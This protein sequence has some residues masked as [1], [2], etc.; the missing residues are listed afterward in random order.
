[1]PAKQQ[2]QKRRGNGE[3][4]IY[5]RPDGKWC[6]Q[7]LLGYSPKTGKA[8]RKTFYGKTRIEVARKVT[9][10]TG[11]VFSGIAP[12][13]TGTMSLSQFISDY[14]WNFKK[15]TIAD[16]TFSWYLDI[17]NVYIVPKLGRY[18]IK[19]IT[20]NLIQRFI[21]AL[22]KENLSHR[23]I[24]A[25]RD[26]LNQLFKHAVD[27]RMLAYNP[28]SPTKLPKQRRNGDLSGKEVKVVPQADREKIMAVAQHD[29]RMK[30]ALTVLMMTGMRTGEFLALRWKDIDFEN[31]TIY[32]QNAIT[33]ENTYDDNGEITKKTTIIG[34]T[35]TAC[36][37]RK[38]SVPH[39]VLEVIKQWRDGLPGYITKTCQIDVLAPDAIIF[40]TERGKLRTYNGFR[41]TYRRFMDENSLHAYPLHT[42]RHTFATMLLEENVNPK[43]VQELLGH[44]DVETTLNTYSHVLPESLNQV[45][46]L[47]ETLYKNTQPGI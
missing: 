27:T 12:L 39:N 11:Q 3:G 9:Q 47:L 21:N 42:Y 40:P 36:S 46:T 31:Q 26:L 16:S 34:D 41:T 13:D 33:K 45:A 35:K 2:R 10:L 5:Q 32:I 1:M 14:L 43:I 44:R 38:I 18:L 25:S 22:S 29:P 24:K 37:V 23:T 6:G 20:P 15:P 17:A 7:V 4:S 28:V 30:L 19:D 8:N